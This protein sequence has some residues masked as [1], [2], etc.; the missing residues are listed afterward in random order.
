MSGSWDGGRTGQY[1]SVAKN[2]EDKFP[3]DPEYEIDHSSALHGFGIKTEH[4]FREDFHP[5]LASGSTWTRGDSPR[6]CRSPYPLRRQCPVLGPPESPLPNRS[7]DARPYSPRRSIL[8]DYQTETSPVSVRSS[9]QSRLPARPHSPQPKPP[10]RP[11]LKQPAKWIPLRPTPGRC[12]PPLP[13]TIN[14]PEITVSP[15]WTAPPARTGAL[16]R[17]SYPSRESFLSEMSLQ[18][19]CPPLACS[20]PKPARAY[21][22]SRAGSAQRSP[23]PT[24]THSLPRS[25]SMGANVRPAAWSSTTRPSSITERWSPPVRVTPAATG[26][27]SSS[28]NSSASPSLDRESD[29]KVRKTVCEITVYFKKDTSQGRIIISPLP[30]KFPLTQNVFLLI[31]VSVNANH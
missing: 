1:T 8:T 29:S 13:P 16:S 15:V 23:S 9:Y 2:T 28:S 24:R 21:S 17:A 3:K 25:H 11:I 27:S 20:T 6:P 10:A 18:A 26:A 5:E 31:S 7:L 14:P 30:Q 19:E 4:S 22:P 12:S